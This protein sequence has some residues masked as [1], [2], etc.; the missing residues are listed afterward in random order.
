MAKREKD[1]GGKRKKGKKVYPIQLHPLSMDWSGRIRRR[2]G[3]KKNSAEE[4]REGGKKYYLASSAMS[5]LR[6]HLATSGRR[7]RV[8]KEKGM[9]GRRREGGRSTTHKYA[10][11]HDH[12]CTSHCRK[13]RLR[14]RKRGG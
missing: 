8:K 4:K 14:G 12:I 11:I 6:R 10:N 7:R 1:L 13:S 2:K 5:L 9:G 3:K